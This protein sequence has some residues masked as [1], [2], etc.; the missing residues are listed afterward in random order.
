M[1]GPEQSSTVSQGLAEG[2]LWLQVLGSNRLTELPPSLANLPKLARLD[3]SANLLVTVPPA[4]GH[5]KTFKELDLRSVLHIV[6]AQT[7]LHKV[8]FCSEAW[9]G[10]SACLTPV[11]SSGSGQM[12]ALCR[13]VLLLATEAKDCTAQVLLMCLCNNRL[14]ASACLHVKLKMCCRHNKDLEPQLAAKAG[15]GLS[16]LLAYLREEDER[17]RLLGI[18]RLKPVPVQASLSGTA[19]QSCWPCCAAGWDLPAQACLFAL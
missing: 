6:C 10:S 3:V 13:I 1:C 17:E 14:L 19:Y 12:S 5:I 7:R 11:A 4:L 8:E 2:D 16:K 9:P 18:E 15:E